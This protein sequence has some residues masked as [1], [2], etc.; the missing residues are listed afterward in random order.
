MKAELADHAAAMR[1]LLQSLRA[2]VW[3]SMAY[4]F[5]TLETT[6]LSAWLKD[7]A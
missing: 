1:A 4:M 5:V 6:K 3:P 2:Y 7:L